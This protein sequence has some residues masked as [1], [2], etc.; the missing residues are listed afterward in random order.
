[1][2]TVRFS[3]IEL[4]FLSVVIVF[5]ASSIGPE[6]LKGAE[7]SKTIELAES[8]ERMRV[9][10][11]V[12]RAEHNGYLPPCRSFESFTAALTTKINCKGPYIDSIPVNPFNNCSRVRFGGCQAGLGGAGWHLETQSGEF[13]ADNDAGCAGL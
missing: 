3:Y 10:L 12:Y 11:D 1:M 6:F 13:R 9:C 5:I 7:K 2:K 4:F 8:L